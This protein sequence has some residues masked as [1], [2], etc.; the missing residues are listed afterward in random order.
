MFRFQ[1]PPG[2]EG[3]AGID[4]KDGGAGKAGKAGKDGK[5]NA[6][7][8]NQAEVRISNRILSTHITGGKDEIFDQWRLF[9]SHASS[10]RPDLQAHAA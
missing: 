2:P 1:G 6:P 9:F 8:G 3:D 5:A 7:V 4:G 10:A